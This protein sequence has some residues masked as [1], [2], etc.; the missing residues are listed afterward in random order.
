MSSIR[1][2]VRQPRSGIQ[3]KHDEFGVTGR[4]DVDYLRKTI[5][6]ADA[7]LIRSRDFPTTEND[8]KAF[9]FN[10]DSSPENDTDADDTYRVSGSYDGASGHFECTDGTCTVTRLGN[11]YVVGTGETWT[12]YTRDTAQVLQDDE[13][14]MYFGWWRRE[15]KSDGALSFANFSGGFYPASHDATNFNS[16]SGT[17]TYGGSRG[18]PV[19]GLSACR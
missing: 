19:C 14:H 17:V 15:Q 4:E 12:F 8:L 10:H 9:K 6:A 3:T 7:A 13:S 2:L 11:R 18:R 1:T 16:L 5:N